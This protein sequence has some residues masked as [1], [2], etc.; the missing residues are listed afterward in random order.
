MSVPEQLSGGFRRHSEEQEGRR[1][2]GVARPT[3]GRD[4]LLS[5]RG[6]QQTVYCRL[7]VS[8]MLLLCGRDCDSQLGLH[9]HLHEADKQ[10]ATGGYRPA[11]CMYT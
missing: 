6:D 3:F 1:L 4:Q 5:H 7:V 10:T 8:D 11:P 2:I 9:I